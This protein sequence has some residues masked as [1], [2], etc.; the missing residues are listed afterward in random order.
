MEKIEN[1]MDLLQKMLSMFMERAWKK[2][3]SRL[4]HFASSGPPGGDLRREY[5]E[6]L[7]TIC[8]PGRVDTPF[9]CS[10]IGVMT[11]AIDGDGTIIPS[12]L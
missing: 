3:N 5:S 12:D 8:E 7:Y 11:F 4:D 9:T 10:P 2:Y 1:D 6:N